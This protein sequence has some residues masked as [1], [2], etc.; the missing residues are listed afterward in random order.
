MNGFA[1]NA[2]LLAVFTHL[3]LSGMLLT[4]LGDPY[5]SDGGSPLWKIHPGSYL[6][7]VAGGVALLPCLTRRPAAWRSLWPHRHLA[8][9]GLCLSGCVVFEAALTGLGNP[10]VLIDTFLPASMLAGSYAR[11]RCRDLARLQRL[12]LAIFAVNALLALAETV[13]Q[14]HLVTPVLDG[15]IAYETANEFRGAALYDHPLTGSACSVI[16]MLMASYLPQRGWRLSYQA[17]MAAALIAFG[18]RVALVTG[19]LA[20]VWLDSGMVVGAV[21][22]RR[23]SASWLLVLT[24]SG[25]VAVYVTVA[26]AFAVG[27]GTRLQ[28]HFYW[29]ASAQVR[30]AQWH[31]L[32]ML[33]TGQWLYGC[34]RPDMLLHVRM[35]DLSFGVQVIE[36]FWLLMFANLGVLGFPLFLTGFGALVLWCWLFSDRRG[37]A[38]IVTVLIIASTS[39]SLARKSPLLL[40]T[41]AAVASVSPALA[42]RSARPVRKPRPLGSA[43]HA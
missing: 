16:G 11:A 31:L 2:A 21:L 6:A 5:V 32:A 33:D 17:L 3:A 19:V 29:D 25:F 39:N 38:I 1:S 22:W 34:A 37:R 24:A 27:F 9:A 12:L 15:H 35:L 13:A 14:A 30:L 36:N 26:L 41:V 10:I 7:Y 42:A 20:L 18:G 4:H 8:L 43:A 23:P 28:N 40:I